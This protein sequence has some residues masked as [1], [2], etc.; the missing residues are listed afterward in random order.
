MHLHPVTADDWETHRD[1][2]LEMLREAP[3]AFWFT[4]ADEA[5]YDEADWRERI[6]GAWLVQARDADGVLG[7]AGLGSHW[8]PERA[9]TATLFGMYV[10]PRAR[11]GG[12]G[13]ALVRA[14]LDEARRLGKSEVVLEVTSSNTAAEGLYARCGFVRTGAVHEHPRR[15]DLCEIEMVHRF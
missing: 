4:Y 15:P 9:T 10:A 5:V 1:V 6:E 7:S 3:E 14:V 2:R 11:G 13:E 12:V 8:E